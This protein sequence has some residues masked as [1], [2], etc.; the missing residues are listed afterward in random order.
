M[1]AN[2]LPM[3]ADVRATIAETKRMLREQLPNYKEVFE[4]LQENISAQVEI[5]KKEQA[6][7]VASVPEVQAQDI[8]DGTVS[9]ALK[10]KIRQRGCAVIHGVFP[11]QVAAQWNEDVKAYLDE[12]DFEERLKHAAVDKYFSTLG[13]GKPQIYGVY[14]SKPQVEARQSDRMKAVQV[15]MNSFWKSE[16]N[17]KQHFDT[18]NILTYADRL[19]RR[20]PHSPPLG[21]SPHVDSGTI[22]RWLDSNFRHVYRNVFSGNWRA[23][24]PFDGE[25]RTEV[26]EIK[27]PAMCSAFRTFQGWTALSP[28]RKNGGTLRL[29]PIV[30]AIPY[31][32]LRSLQDDVPE[33]DFCGALPG[34]ALGVFPEW[35]SLLLEAE[36]SIPNMEPGDCVFWHCDLVHSV[37]AQHEGEFDSN[38]IYIAAVPRCAKNI[39]YVQLQWK[40][41]LRG[42]TPP[43]FATDDFEVNF[44]GRARLE[45]LTPTGK[46]QLNPS[47]MDASKL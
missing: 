14:W 27:S 18:K 20:P 22:E 37:E 34:R 47:S 5:I 10:D 12:N 30:N 31:M 43:D 46:A 23:Y 4:E 24:D 1:P 40:A 45:D 8:I 9:E 28:Q 16:S 21:L 17:G 3:P 29:V 41:F 13:Q 6:A 7:G 39:E 11:R 36:C 2:Y 42:G 32:L 25:G 33:D 44:K 15:F 19:R 26:R 38:V 35:H